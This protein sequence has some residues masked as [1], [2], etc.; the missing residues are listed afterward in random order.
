MRD[1]RF[2][3][4]AAKGRADAAQQA[5]RCTALLRPRH[6]L[7]CCQGSKKLDSPTGQL[8]LLLLHLLSLLSLLLLLLLLLL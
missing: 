6:K 2:F 4:K 1:M 7:P 8:P 5:V 3:R